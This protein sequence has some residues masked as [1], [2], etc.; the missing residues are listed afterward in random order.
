MIILQKFNENLTKIT[1]QCWMQE[2]IKHI[3]SLVTRFSE[4]VFVT[5][6]SKLDGNFFLRFFIF[7]LRN[8]L[9]LAHNNCSLARLQGLKIFGKKNAA[10]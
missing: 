6:L 3:D 9:K 2:D 10:F 8:L 4:R 1:Q 7:C 5:L